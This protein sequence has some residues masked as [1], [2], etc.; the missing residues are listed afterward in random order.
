MVLV[1]GRARRR[2]SQRSPL[3]RLDRDGWLG[4]HR[5]WLLAH[6]DDRTLLSIPL[7]QRASRVGHAGHHAARRIRDPRRDGFENRERA[8]RRLCGDVDRPGRRLHVL[9]HVGVFHVQFGLRDQG[10]GL[11]VRRV[12]MPDRAARP[13]RGGLGPAGESDRRQLERFVKCL[14]RPVSG[15]PRDGLRRPLHADR[16]GVGFEPRCGQ[17]PLV[18]LPRRHGERRHALLLHRQVQRR[19]LVRFSRL[20]RGERAGDG[21]VHALADLR[22]PHDGHQPRQHHLHA[23]PRL[24][25]RI[26]RLLRGPHLQRLPEHDLGVHTGACQPDR[27]GPRRHLVHG[28]REHSERHDL[29]LRRPRRGHR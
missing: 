21:R 22:G 28:R 1:P 7:L 4:E 20:G 8:L 6:G 23:E 18:H 17:R 14:D 3:G 5:H 26:L 11:Q 19:R 12:R 15:L 24:D 9:V 27:V 16:H 10:G 2:R 25:R 13:D 29:L